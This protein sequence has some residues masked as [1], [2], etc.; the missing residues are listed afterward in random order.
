VFDR[1]YVNLFGE[2]PRSIFIK[3]E[4][5]GS[6]TGI[7]IPLDDVPILVTGASVLCV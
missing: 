6:V 1:E 7:T 4:E 3:V 2:R 5:G